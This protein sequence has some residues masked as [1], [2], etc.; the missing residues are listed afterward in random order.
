MDNEYKIKSA[1]DSRTIK[2]AKR[3]INKLRTKEVVTSNKNKTQACFNVSLKLGSGRCGRLILS[4]STSIISFIELPAAVIMKPTN[5]A[6]NNL[7]EM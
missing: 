7:I 5:P 3:F 6:S 4:I 2:N 1:F